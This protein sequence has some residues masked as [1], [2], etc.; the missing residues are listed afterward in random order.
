MIGTVTKLNAYKS[1]KGFFVGIDGKD[2]M[3]FGNPGVKIGDK[4]R[5]ESGFTKDGKLSLKSIRADGPEAFI[6]DKPKEFRAHDAPKDSREEYWR[7]KEKRDIEREPIIT[8]LSCISSACA[9][10]VGRNFEENI[11]V[12]TPII[13]IA[14]RF[15]KYAKSGE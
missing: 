3:F 12:S 6:D 5:Y 9:L 8:R 11:L 7:N 1:G 13:E 2:Y 10:M 15:E 14:K 4:V